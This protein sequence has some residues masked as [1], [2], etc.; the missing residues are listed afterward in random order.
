MEIRRE[1]SASVRAGGGAPAPVKIVVA[2]AVVERD[3]K[4]LVTRRPPGVHLSGLWEFPGGKCEAG[5]SLEACL[6]RELLEELNVEADIG[7]E[8]LATTHEYPDKCVEIHFLGCSLG[9]EPRPQQGQELQWVR[10]R[11]LATLDFPA[12]DAE[13]IRL[14]TDER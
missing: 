9:A 7:R 1:A 13:L 8:L 2:A 12:A 14:L 6:R 4:V 5:E 10:R 3:G 11:D